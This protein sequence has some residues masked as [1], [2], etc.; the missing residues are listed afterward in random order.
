M[1]PMPDR[2]ELF[3]DAQRHSI[4]GCVS[5]LGEHLHTLRGFGLDDRALTQLEQVLEAF[6]DDTGAKRPQA[7]RNALNATLIQMLVLEEELRPR[8]MTAYGALS[9]DA[10]H[11][12]DTHAQRLV[13]LTHALIDQSQQVGA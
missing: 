8:R 13:D 2:A 1:L 7:P 6:A 4:G 5:Q 3:T 11:V 9:E 12:L 10:A